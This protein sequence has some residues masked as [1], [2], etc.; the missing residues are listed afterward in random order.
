MVCHQAAV[1][2]RLQARAE[3]KFSILLTEGDYV[4]EDRSTLITPDRS[5]E[6][7]IR[8]QSVAF[9]R[10]T[11]NAVELGAV[12]PHQLRVVGNQLPFLCC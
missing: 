10:K 6:E 11:A 9:G 3:R 5:D 7:K 12:V 1:S 2:S 4:P 8:Y